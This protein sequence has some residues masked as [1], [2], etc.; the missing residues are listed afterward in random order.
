MK[1]EKW[2]DYDVRFIEVDGE[3]YAPCDDVCK[4]LNITDIKTVFNEPDNRLIALDDYTAVLCMSEFGI[5]KAL[6]LSKNIEALNFKT[7]SGAIMKKLRELIGLEGY[8][9]FKMTSVEV[10]ER[11]DRIL[12]TLYY[13]SSTDQIMVSK[14]VHGGDVEQVPLYS[15]S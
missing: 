1:I 2:F 15:H 14:T 3:W 13:D 4:A 9:V 8:E 7:W 6:L 10:Q 11:I 5:Y 12:D